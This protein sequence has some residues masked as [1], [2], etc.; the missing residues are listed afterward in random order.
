MSGT[1]VLAVSWGILN[2]LPMSL[3]SMTDLQHGS[4]VQERK[5]GCCHASQGLE[6]KLAQPH[7]CILL[8]T[9][10]HSSYAEREEQHI[11]IRMGGLFTTKLG[12]SLPQVA[13]TTYGLMHCRQTA[14]PS[15]AGGEV[16]CHGRWQGRLSYY[17]F[18]FFLL[19]SSWARN[20][21]FAT[22]MILAV[23]MTTPVP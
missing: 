15:L 4:W 13:W 12:D 22:A 2:L 8:V 23:R 6:P 20:Q 17:Y 9:P 7:F 14:V 21:T 16:T 3:S 11:H 18:F 10:S 19:R 1:L 5:S